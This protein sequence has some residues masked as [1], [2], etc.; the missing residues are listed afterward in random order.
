MLKLFTRVSLRLYLLGAFSLTLALLFNQPQFTVEAQNGAA[1]LSLKQITTSTSF[2]VGGTLTY[3]LLVVN[4]GPNTATGIKIED[5]MPDEVSLVSAASSQGTCTPNPTGA[6]CSLNDLPA[7]GFETVT[8][9]VQGNAATLILNWASVSANEPDINLGNNSS[10][11]NTVLHN[12]GD[13]NPNMTVNIP[14]LVM[15]EG[16]TVQASGNLTLPQQT[17]ALLS[18]S[19][20][21]LSQTYLSGA[22]GAWGWQYTAD[23]DAPRNQTV[24]ISAADGAGRQA[25]ITFEVMVNN[26]NR[27]PF[28]LNDFV[29]TKQDKAVFVAVLTNDSDPDG[30][31]VTTASVDTPPQNGIAQIYPDN[32]II[33]GP[34]DGFNGTDSFTYSISDGHGGQSSALVTVSVVA[35]GL[36]NTAPAAGNDQY[37]SFRDAALTITGL[38]V[39]Y[40]DIDPD[41]DTLT[42]T[43]VSSVN[44]AIGSVV[45]NPDQ[46]ITITPASGY[47]GNLV[48]TY[49]VSDGRGGSSSATITVAVIAPSSTNHAPVATAD[50]LSTPRNTPLRISPSDLLANDSDPDGDRLSISGI[51]IGSYYT[52]WMVLNSDGSVTYFPPYY[53]TGTLTGTYRI[54][55]GRGGTAAGSLTLTVGG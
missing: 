46:S 30:D 49:T 25:Q 27:A 34:D 45:L 3:T 37:G 12:T 40:N 16:Q 29:T 48:G 26:V 11:R 21:T 39:M 1:D 47:T 28:A 22:G 51:N 53:F 38:Q 6:A 7:G 5:K 44:P 18:A 8:L 20:G 41:G 50:T 19:V 9:T 36:P 55:D 33:Y 2:D 4:N 15:N 14:V 52:G 24:V 32:T 54:S 35:A 43:S 10:Y 17:G 42:F 13:T 31:S 23:F